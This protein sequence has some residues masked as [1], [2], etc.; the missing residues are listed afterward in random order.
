MSR[1]NELFQNVNPTLKE[2]L[3]GI[4]VWG[5]LF[6]VIFIWFAQS[7]LSF[8]LSLLAGVLAAG[9]MAVHM[10]Y[11]VEGAIELPQED[12]SKHM[13]KGAAIRTVAVIVLVLIFVKMQGNV[14]AL[15]LGLLTLKLGAYLQP[16]THRI[17][18]RIYRKEGRR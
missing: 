17:I 2:L 7:R 6:G 18:Q 12:A 15:F 14:P 16:L 3:A 8:F 1:R 13:A 5:I 4:C 10:L 9:G 11:F